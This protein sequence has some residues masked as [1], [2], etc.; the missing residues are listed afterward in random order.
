[1]EML[2]I[3][4]YPEDFRKKLEKEAQLKKIC[5]CSQLPNKSRLDSSC[6][7]FDFS[8]INDLLALLSLNEKLS[9]SGT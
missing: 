7:L 2:K 6:F 5:H 9:P 4:I 8:L 3:L 1:M